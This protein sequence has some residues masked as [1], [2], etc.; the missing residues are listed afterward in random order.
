M[1]VDDR[2]KSLETQIAN[3]THS[4]EI[5]NDI[6]A[7]R[8]LQHAYGYYLD[9]CLYDEVVAL[10]L[11]DNEVRF[12]GGIFRGRVGAH[13]LYCERF[14]KNFTGGVNGPVFGFLLDHPQMQDVVDVLPDRTLAFGRFRTFMQAGRHQLAKGETRQW[15]EG[16]LYEN[17]YARENGVWKIKILNYRPVWH[18]T[19]EKGWAYTPPN[20]VPFFT[21]TYP[22]DP[23][24]PDALIEPTPA[25]WPET[26]ILP[27][28][29]THPVTG[30]Q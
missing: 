20:F 30:H 13:R 10:F 14:R 29:Y 2:I 3:L 16:G 7:V 19:F 23:T 6:H 15:W 9:K 25:L 27:F 11:D 24:G 5:L 12:M 17:T 22:E 1:T 4:V 28:H 21:T 8:R 18:A 26:E